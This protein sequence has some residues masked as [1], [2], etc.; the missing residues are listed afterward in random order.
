[1]KQKFRVLPYDT[2]WWYSQV[3]MLTMETASRINK[4]KSKTRKMVNI[5]SEQEPWH[6]FMI[7]PTPWF[8]L[9]KQ[10]EQPQYDRRNF[11]CFSF[12]ISRMVRNGW[13]QWEGLGL[14]EENSSDIGTSVM[15]P[16][17][18]EPKWEVTIY[19]IITRF[20]VI[21]I[22]PLTELFCNWRL[23]CN[24]P[25]DDCKYLLFKNISFNTECLLVW[26]N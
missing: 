24:C 8:H 19:I 10:H 15:D 20:I 26:Y 23:F 11:F 14:R 18:R 12:S 3:Y 21:N 4:N 22:A 6:H 9:H 1:M 2:A 17:E 7:S 5:K 25:L 13:S 16:D